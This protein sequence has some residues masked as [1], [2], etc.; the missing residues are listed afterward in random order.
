MPGRRLACQKRLFTIRPTEPRAVTSSIRIGLLLRTHRGS[1]MYRVLTC[2]VT[3]HDWRLVVLAGAICA[4][5][6]AVAIS[7]FHRARASHGRTRAIWV[8]LDAIVGGCGI[9]A[10]HFVAMLA[11]DP[12]AG[13]GYSI[14]VTLL[15]LLF[16]VCIVAIGLCV[17]CPVR[18]T[19]SLRS[20]VRS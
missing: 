14:P 11:Y 1:V 9:W 19:R 18:A 8:C 10:T 6:S 17:H 2:L 20:A 15:S 13:A 3:E 4:F 16:A 12:G 7:L 5:A